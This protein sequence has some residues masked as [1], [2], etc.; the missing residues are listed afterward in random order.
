[1]VIAGMLYGDINGGSWGADSSDA[2][3]V[4]IKHDEFVS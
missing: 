3:E 4:M 1:M 2:E